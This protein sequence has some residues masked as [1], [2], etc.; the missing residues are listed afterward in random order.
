MSQRL[1]AFKLDHVLK[2]YIRGA[3]LND[4]YQARQAHKYLQWMVTE[5]EVP[6]GQWWLT[7]YG[8]S[9]LSDMLDKLSRSPEHGNELV[10]CVLDAVMLTPTEGDKR[11]LSDVH[12]D[13]AIGLS[14]WR[15][16]MTQRLKG[17][18]ISITKACEN[19]AKRRKFKTEGGEYLK[20]GTIR[21]IYYKWLQYYKGNSEK[22]LPSHI[23]KQ[24]QEEKKT[25]E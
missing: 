9:V 22:F 23:L 16:R 3:E 6:A 19:V 17:N 11:N 2:S 21:N 1:P 18:P 5:Q 7:E 25:K 24:M 13:S 15:E 8:K 4:T 10:A 20:W 12:R 14:I